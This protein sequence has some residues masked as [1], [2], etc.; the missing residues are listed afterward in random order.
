MAYKKHD[1]SL[2]TTIEIHLVD[3]KNCCCTSNE[4]LL[5]TTI[6]IHLMDDKN[7]CCTSKPVTRKCPC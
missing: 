6:N 2:P 1:I 5:P 4:P 3:N 7:C